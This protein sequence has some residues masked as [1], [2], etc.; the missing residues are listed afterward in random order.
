MEIMEPRKDCPDCKRKRCMELL[1]WRE[2]ARDGT[3]Y[4]ESMWVCPHCD[5]EMDPYTGEKK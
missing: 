4:Q 1:D 2:E 3:S 5:T